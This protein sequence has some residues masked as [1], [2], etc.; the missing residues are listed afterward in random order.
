MR[1]GLT[2]ERVASATGWRWKGQPSLRLPIT[3]HLP[4]IAL[5]AL[6]GTSVS[7]AESR[8]ATETLG[9]LLACSAP[10]LRARLS[11]FQAQ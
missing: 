9:V 1:Q 11:W 2:L 10:D 3:W 6:E 8:G 7:K 5:E 4:G